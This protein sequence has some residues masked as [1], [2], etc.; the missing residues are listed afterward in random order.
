MH[1]QDSQSQKI[2]SKHW[3]LIFL[4]YIGQY[5]CLF[6]WFLTWI[7]TKALQQTI[8]TV[9]KQLCYA[10]CWT[11][12]IP[13]SSRRCYRRWGC[14]WRICHFIYLFFF[15]WSCN[16]NRNLIASFILKINLFVVYFTGRNL[17]FFQL[18]TK[19][20]LKI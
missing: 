9:R 10:G 8:A 17:R 7:S 20:K 14:R 16:N 3:S 18:P 13:I 15:Y 19:M 1:H 12:R 4:P 6:F 2:V 11:T 5:I